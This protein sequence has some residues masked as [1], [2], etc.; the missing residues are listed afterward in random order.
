ML[1]KLKGTIDG[2]RER[3]GEIADETGDASIQK[4]NERRMAYAGERETAKEIAKANLTD[5]TMC[6][7]MGLGAKVLH[8]AI[9]ASKTVKNISAALSTEPPA[10]TK[11]SEEADPTTTKK[12]K[13][14]TEK[15]PKWM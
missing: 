11:S 2:V 10:F 5:G 13:S 1:N 3:A 15:V 6:K 8:G 4:H 14:I 12:H 7:A 9:A